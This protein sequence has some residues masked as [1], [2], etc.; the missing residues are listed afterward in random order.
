MALASLF[1]KGMSS[2]NQFQ[3][4][5]PVSTLGQQDG[6]SSC[7]YASKPTLGQLDVQTTDVESSDDEET[8][9][10]NAVLLKQI[11]KIAFQLYIFTKQLK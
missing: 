9:N 8:A 5:T 4:S 2:F 7:S 11:S 10:E 6:L 3:I 1:T